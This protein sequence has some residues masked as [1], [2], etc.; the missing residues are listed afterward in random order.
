[1]L[2]GAGGAQGVNIGMMDSAYTVG[3]REILGF[4]NGTFQFNLA[5]IEETCSGAVALQ[6]LDAVY[7][8]EVNM[9]KVRWDARAPHEMID[10]YKQ[11]QAVFEKRGIAKFI[12]VD[13]LV[14]GRYQDNLENMQWWKNFF[15]KNYAGQPVRWRRARPAPAHARA[16]SRSA[17]G[18]H[19][20]LA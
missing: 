14:R 4:L 5:K 13:K 1:M 16:P 10:N 18:A 6:I 20:G 11:I 7:P 17:P 3:R 12:E 2:G 8:G 9:A 19:L 15:A